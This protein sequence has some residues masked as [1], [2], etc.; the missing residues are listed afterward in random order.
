MVDLCHG[1]PM[2]HPL[3]PREKVAR[4]IDDAPEHQT[5]DELADDILAALTSGSGGHAE[6]AGLAEAASGSDWQ[7]YISGRP[8]YKNVTHY[9]E[10]NPP[11]DL[12]FIAEVQEER[13]AAFIAAANPATVL[14]LLAENA[15]LRAE[16]DEWRDTAFKA[17]SANTEA[18]RKL[19]EAVGLL[20]DAI[21]EHSHMTDVDAFEEL[22]NVAATELI[23]VRNFL[24]KE[25][26]RG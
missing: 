25:A 5:A 15:A 23:A 8:E 4:L 14:A 22:G 3:T 19:A 26:E 24:S 11:R 16:R 21:E 9:V 6:L 18:E 17:R 1:D 2:T 10:Q 12:P 7:T 20:R 13:D